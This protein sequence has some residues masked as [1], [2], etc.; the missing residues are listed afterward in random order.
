MKAKEKTGED[1]LFY[2]YTPE[3]IFNKKREL[4]DI[5]SI[6]AKLQN[7][8]TQSILLIKK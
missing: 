8:K 3:Y 4:S 7:P 5:S 6:K 2:T 1:F